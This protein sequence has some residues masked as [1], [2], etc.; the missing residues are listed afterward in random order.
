MREAWAD[1][2][3]RREVQALLRQQ[4]GPAVIGQLQLGAQ[5]ND[6][7]GAGTIDLEDGVITMVD[8]PW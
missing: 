1:P 6:L 5:R 3:H 2:A 7:H 4:I 8:P